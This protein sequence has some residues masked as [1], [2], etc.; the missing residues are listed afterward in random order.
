MS[1]DPTEVIKTLR[2]HWN[3]KSD[4]ITYTTSITGSNEKLTKRLKFSQ[5]AK[6]FDPLG[7]LGPVIVTA[8]LIIQN[9]WK[10]HLD[11]DETVP[12]HLQQIWIEYKDQ[13]PLLNH[14]QSR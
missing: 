13:L 5:I 10:S 2:L 3:L 6:L 1:L 7:L 11:W 9:L 12:P 4:F 8:K 14:V